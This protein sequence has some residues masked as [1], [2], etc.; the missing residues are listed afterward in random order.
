MKTD[1]KRLRPTKSG[2]KVADALLS[3][4]RQ[5]IAETRASVATIVNAGMTLLYWEIGERIRT[6]V[7]NGSRA[8]YGKEILATLSRQL[9]REYGKGFSAKNIRHMMK[10]AE[11]FPENEIVATLSRQL[12]WSHFKELLYLTHPLQKEF[13]AEMCRTRCSKWFFRRLAFSRPLQASCGT[14][15]AKQ[16]N[17]E[18]TYRRGWPLCLPAFIE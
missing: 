18:K 12:S 7:L 8:D 1:S 17:P 13:Y 5:L 15:N 2:E 11:T 4:I 6:E 3:D 9:M 14:I 16:H 10:F